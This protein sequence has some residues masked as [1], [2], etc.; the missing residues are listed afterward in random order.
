MSKKE[1]LYKMLEDGDLRRTS[2]MGIIPSG[3]EIPTVEKLEENLRQSPYFKVKSFVEMEKDEEQP[4]MIGYTAEIEYKEGVFDVD[5]YLKSTDVIDFEI[6]GYGNRIDNQYIEAASK[7]L[8]FWEVVMEF[9][10]NSLESFHLQLKIMDVAV[11]DSLVVVDFLSIRFL[12]SKWLHMTA[13][14]ETPPSPDYLYVL[15]CVYDEKDDKQV[16]WIHTH[17]LHRCGSVELEMVGITSGLEQMESLFNS[18]IKKFLTDPSRE[19]ETF[20][21]GY[22]G[23]DI[24][25]CWERWENAL[26]RFPTNSLGGFEDR[27]EDDV[28]T[29]PSGV[30]FAVE[31]DNMTSPEI[32]ISTLS[33]NPIYYISTEETMRMSALAKERF[34]VFRRIFEEKHSA[35]KNKSFIKKFFSK[36]E[37]EEPQWDFLVKMGLS[38]DANGIDTEKEHLWFRVISFKN[39]F[40][41]AKLLNQ[42]YWISGLNEGDV[43]RYPV[44]FLTDW[45]IYSPEGTYTTDTIYELI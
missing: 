41:E 14:S 32:Y 44:E 21:I 40:I 8:A 3:S 15:H 33:D 42:P 30:L 37:K 10:S 22:D 43:N 45:L 29:E 28:H 6:Y 31:D 34:S 12:S 2:N 38:V 1:D 35:P 16:Y 4:D 25:L 13:Q 18:T 11:P 24:N 19:M 23:M 20:K 7:Q 17:G 5:F 9:S 36:E 27:P 39:E 26:K